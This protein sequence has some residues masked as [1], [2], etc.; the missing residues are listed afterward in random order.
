[1]TRNIFYPDLL[2]PSEQHDARESLAYPL[3][4]RLVEAYGWRVGSITRG[5]CR[6]RTGIT[7]CTDEGWPT[8]NLN[9]GDIKRGQRNMGLGVIA[10]T[11]DGTQ[12]VSTSSF[13]KSTK[14]MTIFSRSAKKD[15]SQNLHLMER[16]KA[17]E[18]GAA[19]MVLE[20]AEDFANESR[21]QK[22]EITWEL[23]PQDQIK[24]MELYI[25][26]I[27]RADLDK[28]TTDRIDA[29]FD[30]H[31]NKTDA[32]T[33]VRAEI[34]ELFN[35]EKWLVCNLNNSHNV[36]VGA[37]RTSWTIPFAILKMQDRYRST[38]D[39]D[40]LK[41]HITVP[42]RRFSSL[43]AID[44][45]YRDDVLAALAMAKLTR[46]GMGD[47]SRT[48]NDFFPTSIS[49]GAWVEAGMCAYS[50]GHRSNHFVLVD[51]A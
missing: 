3:A 15:S 30:A 34:D 39:S 42:F 17:Y 20:M 32:T 13:M 22:L 35:C 28:A 41:Q 1:M 18:Q 14:P 31:N 23:S 9:V 51:K 45:R 46:E 4:C 25:G 27:A 37:M 50:F 5:N 49:H 6:E 26:R 36:I 2:S 10:L 43:Q 38:L 8:M 47:A 21:K 40:A 29:A 48:V 11:Y 44:A 16:A 7:L 33:S 19:N 24:L 12:S